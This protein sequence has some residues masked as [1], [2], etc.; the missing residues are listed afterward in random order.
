VV[1]ASGSAQLPA[2]VQSKND[3]VTVLPASVDS[4]RRH[5]DLFIAGLRQR[6]TS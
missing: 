2:T 6:L 1:A 4:A 5:H 3:A